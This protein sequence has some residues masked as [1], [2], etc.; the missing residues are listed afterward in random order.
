VKIYIPSYRRY[1]TIHGGTLKWIPSGLL[2]EVVVVVRDEE[3]DWYVKSLDYQRRQH[4]LQL[5]CLRGVNGISDTR[6][7]I[8]L[9]AQSQGEE[10]FCTM[11]DD[12]MFAVRKSPETTSLRPQGVADFVEMMMTLEVLC[13]EYAQVAISLRQGNNNVGVGPPPLM[14]E[15]GRAIRVCAFRTKEFNTCTHNRV[16]VMEDI[17]VTLQLLSS[18]YKNAVLYYWANDQ[19]Q[20]NAPGGC[21][22]WRTH[23]VHDA[24]ARKMAELWPGICTLRQKENKTGGE[25]GTRT[26]IT[27]QWKKVYEQGGRL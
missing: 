2:R 4:G 27:V 3:Y 1:N 14:Q 11:D 5:L 6:E 13:T 10:C 23:E 24:A 19:K 21:S 8:G 26:E 18:G 20:T 16:S 15:N 12:V 17:D 7:M 9:A 25:F 22:S